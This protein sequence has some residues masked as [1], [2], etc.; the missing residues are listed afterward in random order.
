M[1]T[2]QSQA[3]DY[4]SA[5]GR[6][7][8]AALF[9]LGGI[10]KLAAPAGTIGYIAAAGLPFP[11]L[12]Y[13]V[14]IFVEVVLSLALVVGYRTHLTAALMAVFTLATAFGFHFNLADQGQFIQFFKN[15]SITGGLL[16]VAAFGAGGLSLDARRLARS[17]G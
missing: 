9:L 10:R 14:A 16:Q 8:L 6:V 15:I 7:L 3:A 5:A 12:A 1:N 4:L 11:E 13:G 17:A 2:Q